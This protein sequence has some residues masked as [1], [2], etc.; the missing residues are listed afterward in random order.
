MNI[1]SKKNKVKRNIVCRNSFNF[2]VI[3]PDMRNI[4]ILFLLATTLS[5][6]AQ[7]GGK[8]S[9]EFMR[10]PEVARI[11]ALGG[12]NISTAGEDV[13]MFQANPAALNDSMNQRLSLNYLPH[14]ADTKKISAYYADNVKGTGSWGFGLQFMDYG[15]MERRDANGTLIGDVYAN[16]YAFLVSKSHRVGMFGVGA[17]MKFAGS[18]IDAYSTNAIL[19]DMGA[20][21]YH[22]RAEFNVGLAIKNIGFLLSDYTENSDS[23][24]PF[25]VQL[26]LSYKFEH[27]PLRLST[28]IHHLQQFD[29]VY[30]DEDQSTQIDDEGNEIPEEKTT[31]DKIMRHF[32][33][34]TEF[35]LS[36]NFQL[37]AG[38]NHLRRKE[39]VRENIKGL[40]GWSFGGMLKVNAFEI[41]FTRSYFHLAGGTT[42]L[43]LVT[44]L[45]R[46][47]FKRR[48]GKDRKKES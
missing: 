33:F 35:V 30:L 16:E 42:V 29:I 3:I 12:L 18:K 36:K 32:T 31:G 21:F 11:S 22:P 6:H 46:I 8:S 44:D 15:K 7:I 4:S 23:K 2:K 27:A 25:D 48:L 45:D 40:A 1:Q 41:N 20:M 37:R 9:Y 26:G 34:G 28:T 47:F 17:T 38:Y 14:Y 10:L 13:N 5:L 39:M 19:M 24:V 43:T